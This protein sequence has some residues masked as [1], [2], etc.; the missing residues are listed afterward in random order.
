VLAGQHPEEP[1]PGLVA[2]QPVEG[3]GRFHIYKCR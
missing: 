1:Q 3:R 2:Q